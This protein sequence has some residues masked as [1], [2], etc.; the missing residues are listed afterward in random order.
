MKKNKKGLSDIVTNVLIILLV[1]VAVGIIWRFVSPAIRTGA[2]GIEGSADCLKAN[3][4]AVSCKM[5]AAGNYNI[6]VKRNSGA[7]TVSELRFVFSNAAGEQRVNSTTNAGIAEL[8]TRTYNHVIVEGFSAGYFDVA[9]VVTSSNGNT[10]VCAVTN[11]R[12]ACS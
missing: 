3:F 2:G 9:P 7:A 1:L 8:E 6:T 11:T 5:N 10:Q 4:E 12:V